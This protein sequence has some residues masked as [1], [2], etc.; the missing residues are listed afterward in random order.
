MVSNVQNAVG[1]TGVSLYLARDWDM[2]REMVLNPIVVTVD[3]EAP[4]D[5]EWRG[6]FY[7]DSN[8]YDASQ[9]YRI[10]ALTLEDQPLAL[11]STKF[12]FQKRSFSGLLS[13]S[14]IDAF[15]EKYGL[16]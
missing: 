3:I 10:L 11:V 6:S 13:I 7:L 9:Y 5:T 8:F 16:V 15:I 12:M 1:G 14:T 2:T 4:F